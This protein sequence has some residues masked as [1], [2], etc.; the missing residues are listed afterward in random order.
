MSEEIT[1]IN[2]HQPASDNYCSN[3]GQIIRPKP[4][5]WKGLVLELTTNW[6]GTDNRFYRTVTSLT[7]RPHMVIKEYLAGNRVKYIGPLSYLILMGFLYILSFEILGL[8]PQDVFKVAGEG[9]GGF[10][11]PA[12]TSE[13]QREFMELYLNVLSK[14]MRIL[15]GIMIP[16]LALSLNIFYRGRRNYLENFLLSAYLTSHVV[17]LNILSNIIFFSIGDMFLFLS[18]FISIGYYIWT[19]GSLNPQKSKLWTYTKP[20]F[21]WVTGYLGYIIILMM[22]TI[23]LVVQTL[24]QS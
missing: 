19:I 16:F 21:V 5:T 24:S 2:C 17:W 4:I 11:D 18:M 8:S 6:F 9:F 23:V 20:I 1:C 13:R 15:V 3:C 7:I 22:V 10:G 14:N 12:A